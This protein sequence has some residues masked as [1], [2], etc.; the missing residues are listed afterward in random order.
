MQKSFTE[1]VTDLAFGQLKN[2][3]LTD[4]SD[5]GEINPAHEDQLLSLTNKG[6]IDITTR[7]KI[8]T[9]TSVVTFVSGTNDYTISDQADNNLVKVV[10]IDAVPTGYEVITANKRIFTP[11]TT[12]HITQPSMWVIRFTDEFMEA[13]GPAVDVVKQLLHPRLITNS[14]MDITLPPTMFEAL[15]LYVSGLYLS[16]MGGDE[17]TKKGDAYYGLYLKMMTDDEIQNSSSTSEIEDNDTRF[18]DRGFV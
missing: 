11:K 16:H 13:Y 18:V 6:L 17:H 7:K 8:I 1:F 9:E 12:R 15:E 10:Q 3:A 4:D 14:N 2:T 5:T